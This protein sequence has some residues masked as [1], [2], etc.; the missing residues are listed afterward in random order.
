VLHDFFTFR[1]PT[2]DQELLNMHAT[3]SQSHYN[4]YDFSGRVIRPTL[5]PVP[6]K[7]QHSQQTDINFPVGYETAI[8]ARHCPQTHLLIRTANE[9]FQVTICVH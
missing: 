4:I 1:Q 6:D 3:R 2:A 8:S 7:T 9:I 5:R